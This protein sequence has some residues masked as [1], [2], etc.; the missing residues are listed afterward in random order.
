MIL[1]DSDKLQ[2]DIDKY[3]VDDTGKFI[4]MVQIQHPVDAIP[5]EALRDWLGTIPFHD[6]SDGNG[7]CVVCFKQDLEKAIK[8]LNHFRG[9]TE[10]VEEEQKW[11]VIKP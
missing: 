7:A 2:R 6:L 9:G 3:H 4:H 8:N 10:M 11:R 5:V 1:I